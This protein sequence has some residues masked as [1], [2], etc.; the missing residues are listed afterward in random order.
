MPQN[1]LKRKKPIFG[2]EK[3][4]GFTGKIPLYLFGNVAFIL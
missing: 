3:Y 4:L 2:G 1:F